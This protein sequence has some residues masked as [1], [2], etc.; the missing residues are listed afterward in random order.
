MTVALSYEFNATIFDVS[1]NLVIALQPR[2]N[3]A[4]TALTNIVSDC[5][6]LTSSNENQDLRVSLAVA[7]AI[8]EFKAAQ[9]AFPDACDYLESTEDTA[10]CTKQLASLPQ[11]WTTYHGCYNSVKQICH[12]EEASTE[13]E[14]SLQTHTRIIDMQ[15]KLQTKMEEY[16]NLVDTVSE[17]RDQVLD[18]WNET[19]V[20]MQTTL[21]TMK[22][23]SNSL[24][25]LHRDNFAKAEE[26][27]R[28]LSLNLETSSKKV[29]DLGSVAQSAVESLSLATLLQ[30][31]LVSEKLK[32][33]AQ[34]LSNHLKAAHDSSVEHFELQFDKTLSK[35]AQSSDFILLNHV[36]Q[37]SLQLSLLMSDLEKSQK[38]NLD[39]QE[40]LHTKVRELNNDIEGFT[41]NVKQGLE[42]SQTLLTMIRSKVQ[43]VNGIVQVFSQPVKSAIQLG[44]LLIMIRA[45]FV[46]GMYTSVGL[47]VGS[48]IAVF[49][50]QNI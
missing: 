30:Q 41:E 19:F 37:V 5:G 3:C 6:R 46:G 12:M 42:A 20:F 45:A 10:I 35:L 18:F 13:C 40:E 1:R 9:I 15:E 26:G 23:A 48:G 4:R 43:L 49:L 17:R 29:Q 2:S 39:M 33:D 34:D 28:E 38:T 31:E 14:R 50:M 7:L 8:C 44:S 24:S 25:N 16:W 11:W 22:A 21:D 47:V 27:F 32:N 36:Q